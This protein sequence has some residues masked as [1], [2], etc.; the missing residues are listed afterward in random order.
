M[1]ILGIGKRLLSTLF[2]VIIMLWS[3]D[4]KCQDCPQGVKAERS[5]Y[6]KAVQ[7]FQKGKYHESAVL[8]RKVV[9][10]NSK[11]PDP[12]F[13]LG[14][15]SVMKEDSPGIIGRY[16]S[17]V[18]ELCPDYPNALA[19]YYMG[20]VNYTKES[21]AEATQNL[22]RFFDIANQESKRE[23]DA[24]YEEA[25][26]YL[27][28]SQFLAEAYEN[29]VPFNPVVM[30]G[31]SSKSNEMLPYITLDG[32]EAYYLRIVSTNKEK[33]FYAKELD[34]RVPKLYMS[35]KKDGKFSSG[36]ELKAP[37]NLHESEGGV[38]LIAN[39]NLLYYSVMTHERNGYNNCDIYFSR[40]VNGEWQPIE[41]AGSN[42]N[43]AKSWESQPSIT[44]DG[45]YL[46]FASNRPGGSGGTDIW[47]CRRL[48]NGDWSRA[49]NLGST[50]NTPGNEKCPFISADG[51]TL[52]F[53]S[54]GWQGFGGYDMYFIKLNDPHAQYP[55]NMG[56]PVNG[57]KD[58][59][60][61]GVSADG[62]K[63]YFSGRSTEWTG[64]GS[65][66]IFEF[67]L[68]PAARPEAMK[69]VK[70]SVVDI[71]QNP[72]EATLNVSLP[73][74][75]DPWEYLPTKGESSYGIVVPISSP[76]LLWA[77][78][79]NCWP[80]V[81]IY[82]ARD[83]SAKEGVSLTL[84]PLEQ[85][86]HYDLPQD[87]FSKSHNL[88]EDI[89]DVFAQFL[90]SHPLIHIN[91]GGKDAQRIYERLIARKL[92]PERLSVNSSEE[93]NQITITRIQ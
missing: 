29:Q 23:Y 64:V 8:M 81:K 5:N 77:S 19:H 58:D 47:R 36:E 66:D 69:V 84:K 37:F 67:E 12:Y 45:K 25:S 27:Y 17:K 73:H 7:L 10:K 21:Y 53:A 44:A 78:A 3:I 13:Y 71:D 6:E 82:S 30:Q 42:V 11:S 18:L 9:N 40:K 89:V 50:V 31:I 16:F 80:E 52:Y 55:T 39:N 22:N 88:G 85:K 28:W 90:L 4:A 87:I 79:P 60:C 83:V 14:M 49:E 41:N 35:K 62:K 70:V 65:A 61:F 63:A 20:L 91:I 68:Y 34:E 72:I 32:E 59:I 26:S 57:E 51:A 33:T 93:K 38:S 1:R 24:V 43:N 48:P 15:C 56:L 46:Y 92:R 2:L 76:A 75:D 86:R 74:Q 54:D